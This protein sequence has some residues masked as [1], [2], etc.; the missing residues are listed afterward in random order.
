MVLVTIRPALANAPR[1]IA[2]SGAPAG[3]MPC[4]FRISFA[5]ELSL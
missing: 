3:G 5:Q 1:S 2:E 4:T